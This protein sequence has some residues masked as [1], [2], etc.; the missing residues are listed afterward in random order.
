MDSH[1]DGAMEFTLNGT[2]VTDG[3]R[4]L[5][6][7]DELHGPVDEP[8]K[9]P[10]EEYQVFSKLK[11]SKHFEARPDTVH[12]SGFVLGLAAAALG[13]APQQQWRF[14]HRRR[15]GDPLLGRLRTMLRRQRRYLVALLRRRGQRHGQRRRRHTPAPSKDRRHLLTLDSCHRHRHRHPSRPS[16]LGAA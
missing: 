7:P 10:L 3:V 2:V 5:L 16:C 9:N 12:F 4:E 14:L 6:V 13:D 8:A 15:R 1:G 11:R